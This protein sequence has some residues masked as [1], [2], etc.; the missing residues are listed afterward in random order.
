MGSES[1]G[2]PA[3]LLGILIE[4]IFACSRARSD[5]RLHRGHF[6]WLVVPHCPYDAIQMSFDCGAGMTGLAVGFP[7]DTGDFL[8][9]PGV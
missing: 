4:C 1:T 2:E 6:G 3:T 7:F 8:L 5:D 9:V